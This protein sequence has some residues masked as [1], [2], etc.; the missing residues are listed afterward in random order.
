[1]KR[2]ALPLLA[3]LALTA[4]AANPGGSGQIGDACGELGWGRIG[5][6][7]LGAA[8]GAFLGSQVG[9]G[10]TTR[11]IAT[12]VGT[13]AGAGAGLYAGSSIDKGQCE[14]ARMARTRALDTGGIG[15]SISW[16]QGNASGSFT[17]IRE[18]RDATGATCREFSQTIYID[19]RAETGTGRACRRPDGRWQIV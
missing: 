19:G 9:G 2:I 10:T 16:N 7:V 8:G 15:Q 11:T 3:G 18:G 12:A 13:L 4:C 17:P 5:G 1:M 6:T 14:Q